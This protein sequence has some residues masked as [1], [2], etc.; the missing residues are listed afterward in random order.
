[1]VLCD[2]W[3]EILFWIFWKQIKFCMNIG[4]LFKGIE[5]FLACK[6]G[7]YYQLKVIVEFNSCDLVK[8]V[9]LMGG[10]SVKD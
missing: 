7:L 9:I 1:M 10:I 2:N 6:F 8:V 3:V 5:W 4:E